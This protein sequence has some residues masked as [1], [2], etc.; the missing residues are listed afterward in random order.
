MRRSEVS[1]SEQTMITGS[2]G[3]ISETGERILA[4][5]RETQNKI[6]T[7]RERNHK[8]L[9]TLGTNRGPGGEAGW[10]WR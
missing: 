10:G 3:G 7:K 1:Q 2:H 8:R 4:K 6:K 9:L 5:G